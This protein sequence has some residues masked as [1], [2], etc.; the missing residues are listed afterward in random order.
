MKKT[1]SSWLALGFILSLAATGLARTPSTGAAEFKITVRVYDYA[2]VSPRTLSKAQR[3]AARVFRQAGIE[4]EWLNCLDPEQ[5]GGFSAE[6]DGAMGATDLI[7]RILP[8][9]MGRKMAARRGEC[10]RALLE[11]QKGHPYVANVFYECVQEQADNGQSTETVVLGSAIAH[12]IGHLLSLSH[13][14]IGLMRA[15]WRR[16]DFQQ[17]ATG[18]LL[19]VGKQVKTIQGN[20]LRRVDAQ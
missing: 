12:E 6:C 11:V 4:T 16:K 7:M 10:G 14:R 8:Q 19:F 2:Q 9:T 1:F 5:E 18:N 3:D 15:G 20:L 17:A 13:S